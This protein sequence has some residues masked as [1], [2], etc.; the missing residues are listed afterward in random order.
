MT[1]SGLRSLGIGAEKEVLVT[2]EQRS[3]HIHVIGTTGMG[4]SRWLEKMIRDDIL[5]GKGLCFL[6]PS[7]KGNTMK[8]VLAFCERIGFKKVLLINPHDRHK[9]KKIV[10]LNP[11][12]EYKTTTVEHV[13]S[14]IRVLFDMKN[15]AQF[16][17][18]EHYMPSLIGVLW[19][20]GFTLAES[21]YFTDF[22]NA[23]YR[24]HRE[25]ILERSEYYSAKRG[26]T[27]HDAIRIRGAFTNLTTF[28]EIGS[29][30][31]RLNPVFHETLKLMFGSSEQLD[32]CQLIKNGWVILVNLHQGGGISGLHSKFLATA[33]INEIMS[34]IERMERCKYYLYID[35]CGQYA[36]DKLA[37][38]LEYKRQS[39]LSVV[40]SHQLRSQFEDENVK[41]AVIGMTRTKVAFYE[42]DPEERMKTVKMMYGGDLPDREVAEA[43]KHLRKQH[44]VVMTDE[45]EPT[46]IRVPDVSGEDDASE[47]FY[48]EIYSKPWYLEAN[49]V[50]HDLE[51]RLY[52]N[53]REIKTK[54]QPHCPPA[55]TKRE[56]VVSKAT[57]H[58][59]LPPERPPSVFD[60][61]QESL[62]VQR[63]QQVTGEDV[64]TDRKSVV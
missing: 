61:Y 63:N 39:G 31:R 11:F 59:D 7:H 46:F 14:T 16:A 23:L 19:Q 36:N 13:Y 22:Y 12:R 34:A 52:E 2:E 55:P 43:L 10:P 1:N 38:L 40:L 37:N 45:R 64:R 24:K 4:K 58:S 3:S 15:Q 49:E 53:E 29:T 56:D 57:V 42:P 51:Q 20:A 33:V 50:I 62:R 25:R 27:D 44:A 21:I 47:D 8:R 5:S 54:P 32:W 41:R 26:E 30:F 18:V 48:E 9:Y 17:F 35:E 6:D 28:R 60:I